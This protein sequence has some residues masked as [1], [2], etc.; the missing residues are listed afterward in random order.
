MQATSRFIDDPQANRELHEWAW[1]E[2]LCF[3]KPPEAIGLIRFDNDLCALYFVRV[4]KHGHERLEPGLTAQ[5]VRT[6]K[7]PPNGSMVLMG[8]EGGRHF[9][10]RDPSKVLQYPPDDHW[11][12]DIPVMLPDGRIG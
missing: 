3:G 11:F 4:N 10:N 6:Y 8:C 5:H 9:Y 2:A 1:H 12:W 7:G